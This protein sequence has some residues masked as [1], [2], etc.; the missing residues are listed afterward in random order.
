MRIFIELCTIFSLFCE[1]IGA[2]VQPTEIN[3]SSRTDCIVEISGDDL[4]AQIDSAIKNKEMVSSLLQKASNTRFK[5]FNADQ[6]AKLLFFAVEKDLEDVVE[7]CADNRFDLNILNEHKK[8]PLIIA[9]EHR[10]YKIVEY[11]LVSQANPNAMDPYTEYSPLMIAAGRGDV[12]LVRMLLCKGADVNAVSYLGCTPLSLAIEYNHPHITQMLIDAGANI[13]SSMDMYYSYNRAKNPRLRSDINVA[14]EPLKE[15][16]EP[17]TVEKVKP[18]QTQPS[19][20]SS[21]RSFFGH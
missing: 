2:M 5:A 11:L 14:I 21:F 1:E 13:P 9:T 12:R 6:K 7:Y 19:V 8:T 20:W 10:N 15:K 16:V 18:S 17:K 3:N 4:F